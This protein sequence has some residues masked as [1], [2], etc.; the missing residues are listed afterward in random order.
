M[1]A[2]STSMRKVATGLCKKL[3]NSCVLTKATPG[4]YNPVTGKTDEV[5]QD[6]PIYSAQNSKASLMFGMS[7]DNTNLSGFDDEGVIIPWFGHKIDTTWLYNG[8][9]ILSV[10]EI[11]SQDDVIIYTIQV[12][13]KK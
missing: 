6:F 11:M 13:E 2:F 5:S 4:Q 12:G 1:G 9:N 3:G 8:S 7:G 10:S